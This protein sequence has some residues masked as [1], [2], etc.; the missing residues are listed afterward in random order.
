MVN[1]P[2]SAVCWISTG[3]AVGAALGAQA[4]TS[5]INTTPM[6]N[7]F[8]VICRFTF[9]GF[10]GFVLLDNDFI[11]IQDD[12]QIVIVTKPEV[13][14]HLIA[15]NPGDITVEAYWRLNFYCSLN[16]IFDDC[17]PALRQVHMQRDI[18]FCFCL[19]NQSD[20]AKRNQWG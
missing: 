3:F 10:C 11:L 18:G 5:K 13:S 20:L 8:R 17:I 4:L 1:A 14:N 7:T 15:A 16:R 6:I 19:V 12:G 9:A 2:A